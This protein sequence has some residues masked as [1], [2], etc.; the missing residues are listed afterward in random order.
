M[1]LS[2][3]RFSWLVMLSPELATARRDLPCRAAMWRVAR[4]A[5]FLVA[6][7][8]IGAAADEADGA[9]ADG[10]AACELGDD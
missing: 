9:G 4:L 6:I 5:L 1:R 3:W 7:D 8:F 10:I 2:S